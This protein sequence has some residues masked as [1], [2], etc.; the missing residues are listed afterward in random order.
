M[1]SILFFKGKVKPYKNN[2]NR[3]LADRAELMRYIRLKREKIEGDSVV[4]IQ[5][6]IYKIIK[7]LY[8]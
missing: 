7:K 5:N 6:E 2:K 4:L 8:R 3:I 1:N